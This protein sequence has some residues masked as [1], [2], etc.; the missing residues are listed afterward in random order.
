MLE[1]IL[2]WLAHHLQESIASAAVVIIAGSIVIRIVKN[3][4]SIKG[5]E[6]VIQSARGDIKNAN[7]KG[8]DNSVTIK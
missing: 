4:N 1:S 3:K 8:K 7:V 6:N 5:N 2:E